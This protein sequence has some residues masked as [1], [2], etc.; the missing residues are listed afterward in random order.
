MLE[1][2][3]DNA[4]ANVGELHGKF[5]LVFEKFL[6]RPLDR[7]LRFFMVE[8]MK[9]EVAAP[10]EPWVE[11]CETIHGGLVFVGIEQHK[12]ESFLLKPTTRAG[13]ESHAEL[14]FVQRNIPM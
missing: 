9:Y 8:I 1:L 4:T 14:N 10:R 11:K 7:S 13:E 6:R 2:T 3:K 12:A 5:G